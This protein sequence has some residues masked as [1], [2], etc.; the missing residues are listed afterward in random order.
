MAQDNFKIR[1]FPPDAPSRRAEPREASA[2]VNPLA[3]VPLE[4]DIADMSRYVNCAQVESSIWDFRFYFTEVTALSFPTFQLRHALR[5]AVVM[6]PAHAK[7]FAAALAER[8][9]AWEAENGEIQVP[10][11]APAAKEEETLQ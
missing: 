3:Q 9:A 5:A 10:E 4:G 8:L 1:G 7:A 6:S 11:G 2:S